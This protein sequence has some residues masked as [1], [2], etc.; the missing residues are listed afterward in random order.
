MT[1]FTQAVLSQVQHAWL[2]T[3][4]ELYFG[5]V[6]ALTVN[7]TQ[8]FASSPLK[9]E[10]DLL[11]F[12]ASGKMPRKTTNDDDV[13]EVTETLQS[14]IELLCSPIA[15]GNGYT[16]PDGFWKQDPIGTTLIRV[17]WWLRGEELIS[18]DE[19]AKLLFPKRSS[20]GALQALIY[21]ITEGELQAYPNPFATNPR[22]KGRMVLRSEVEA[23]RQ[24]MEPPQ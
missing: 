14:M 21:R 5:G 22:N 1:T 19:A 2:K 7:L 12:V 4:Q 17:V 11:E 18:L 23:L 6:D 24:R 8:P 13:A 16:I 3:G 10:C 9:T 20:G 15:G